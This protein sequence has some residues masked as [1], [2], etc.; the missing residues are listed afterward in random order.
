MKKKKSPLASLKK[1]KLLLLDIDGILT[2]GRIFYVEGTGWSCNYSVIDGYG[3]RML[4]RAGI[5]TGVISGGDFISHRKRA[6]VL[7]MEHIYLGNESKTGAFEEILRKTGLKPE[8]VA[9]MGDELF[10]LPILREVGFSA[11]VA[12]APSEVKKAVDYIAKRPGG[13]GAVREVI[14]LLLKAQGKYPKV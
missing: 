6:E 4:Q 9:Y 12:H 5:P 10:D 13:H 11:S 2:D 8:E 7:K 3:I 14:E 1:I